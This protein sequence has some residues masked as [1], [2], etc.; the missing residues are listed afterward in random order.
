MNNKEE[1]AYVIVDNLSVSVEKFIFNV[2]LM[3]FILLF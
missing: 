2:I 1:L 3:L